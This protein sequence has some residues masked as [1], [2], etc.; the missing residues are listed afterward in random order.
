MLQS[1]AKTFTMCQ[2]L[3]MNLAVSHSVFV[4]RRRAMPANGGTIC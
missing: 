2:G 3:E 4:V 1:P